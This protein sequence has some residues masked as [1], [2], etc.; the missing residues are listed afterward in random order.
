[1]RLQGIEWDRIHFGP[2]PPITEDQAED[3]PPAAARER[4]PTSERRL[5]ILGSGPPMGKLML[6]SI[7]IFRVFL[8]KK[9]ICGLRNGFLKCVIYWLV[10]GVYNYIY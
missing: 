2:T 5:H 3:Y 1:M 7:R 4:P 9:V 8:R 10:A 6:V